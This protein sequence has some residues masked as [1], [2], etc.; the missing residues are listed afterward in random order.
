MDPDEVDIGL[1]GKRNQAIGGHL[2]DPDLR[3]LG[4]EDVAGMDVDD[5][6]AARNIVNETGGHILIHVPVAPA[7]E[8]P[9]HVQIEGGNSPGDR[10]DA[11]GIHAGIYVDYTVN[12]VNV[13]PQYLIDPEGD[14]LSLQFIAVYA[15]DK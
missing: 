9:V 2:V 15:C 1:P 13:L 6:V 14:I 4:Q 12:A 7:R 3:D 11:K 8:Y 10:I 5:K